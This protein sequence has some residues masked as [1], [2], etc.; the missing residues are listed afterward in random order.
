MEKVL[1]ITRRDGAIMSITESCIQSAEKP[2][3]FTVAVTGDNG[4]V[5][6]LVDDGGLKAFIPKEIVDINQLKVI[7]GEITLNADLYQH[8]F[9]EALKRRRKELPSLNDEH[10]DWILTHP[11]L[12]L[13][14]P[15]Y[16]L[17]KWPGMLRC[18]SLYLRPYE[19]CLGGVLEA[20]LT[21]DELSFEWQGETV[22]LLRVIGSPLSGI[23]TFFA[24]SPSRKTIFHGAGMPHWFDH[25]KTFKT[26]AQRYP[27]S[28]KENDLQTKN[29]MVEI[30]NYNNDS[31][32]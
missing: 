28:L 7:A 10:L 9:R 17:L 20:W 6:N 3:H 11:S 30:A 32:C 25:F 2:T 18:D 21:C 12:V 8:W 29:L 16:F 24:F 14:N 23:N 26:I 19:C 5:W 1:E 13:N 31:V 22:L 4:S 15:A 27:L